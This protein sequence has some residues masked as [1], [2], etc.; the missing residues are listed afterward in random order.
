MTAEVATEATNSEL[1]GRQA[2]GASGTAPF[3]PAGQLDPR[4]QR[5][6]KIILM[7]IMAF[8]LL[9]GAYW[10]VLTPAWSAI[11]EAQH[12]GY[13]EAIARGHGIPTV[14]EDL[15]SNTEVQ[16]IK[17]TPTSP[18]RSHPYQPSVGDLNWGPTSHQYEAIHG[19]TYYS[20]MAPAYWIG[21]PSGT[22]GSLYMIRAATAFLA[23]LAIPLVWMLARRLFPDKPSI[24]LLSAAVLTVLDSTFLGSIGNEPMVLVL[25]TATMVLLLRA[26]DDPRS[27]RMAALFGAA[28]AA[29][30]ITKTTSLALIPLC[31]I[32]VIAWLVRRRPPWSIAIR[33]IAV[34]GAA[35]ILTITP[36][37]AWNF[38]A[39]GALSASKQT[40]ELTG[41]VQ[42]PPTDFS[43][44]LFFKH[45][46]GA[47]DSGVWAN[48]ATNDPTFTHYWELVFVGSAIA[49]V[50]ASA[51]R[52]RWRDLG[53]LL[54][55]A[56][57]LPMAFLALEGIVVV[58]FGG[59]GGP[60]GRH[61]VVALGPTSVLIAASWVAVFGERWGTP[62]VASG[63]VGSLL[64]A[65]PMYEQIIET[66]YLG[67][68]RPGGVAPVLNQTWSDG[69]LLTKSVQIEANCAI[70]ALGVGFQD[71]AIPAQIEVI[72]S[73][74]RSIT[75]NIDEST[76]PGEWKVRSFIP[77]Y[78]LD[79]PVSGTVTITNSANTG[80]NAATG[81]PA[82]WISMD[83]HAADPVVMVFCPVPDPDE[84][85]FESVYPILHPG[86]VTL[87]MLRG[88]PVGFAV[89]GG[90]GA[91][92]T[93][94]WAAADSWKA[95]RNKRV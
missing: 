48:Q 59:G 34:A 14:G 78:E 29:T 65:V 50:V 84:V 27:A 61:L 49:G 32:F 63:L 11:D 37:L 76:L 60:M 17:A 93:F 58:V 19:P 71:N 90:L 47:R 44:E 87:G 79:Q 95:M 69:V 13:V 41:G 67:T 42:A 20:L 94:G 86:W 4:S 82:D 38:H 25:G 12:F 35:A 18:Y 56:S 53:A 36:W 81:D 1:Q 54:W 23:V 73:D 6:H 8:G 62:V 9:K 15:I 55:C 28:G 26:L 57:A 46:D 70:H 21:A 33:W 24:W 2:T 77:T 83:G 43:L 45:L 88:V 80:I 64:I 30:I 39:Y 5:W 51:L 66:T 10:V 7:V 31:G 85:T 72:T 89:L 75:G 74:G 52:R 22:A 3:L 16:S 91:T 92:A 40:E 68:Q